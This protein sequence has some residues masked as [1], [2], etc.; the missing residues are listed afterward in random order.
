MYLQF[1]DLWPGRRLSEYKYMLCKRE[2][3]SLNIQHLCKS[4]A[5]LHVPEAPGLADANKRSLE[6]TGQLCIS[7]TELQV[8]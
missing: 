4:W 3:M 1:K 2:D 5:W 7:H 6:Q 8:Q